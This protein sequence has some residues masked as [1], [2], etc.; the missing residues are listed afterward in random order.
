MLDFFL[1]GG[2]GSHGL[3]VDFEVFLNPHRNNVGKCCPTLIGEIGQLQAVLR[4]NNGFFLGQFLPV[5]ISYIDQL[6]TE[7]VFWFSFVQKITNTG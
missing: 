3:T 5:P 6:I 7:V 4:K 1:G 2:G